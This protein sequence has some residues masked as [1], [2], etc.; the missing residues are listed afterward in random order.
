[1]DG[2]SLPSP[3]GLLRSFS[4]GGGRGWDKR[5]MSADS[6]DSAEDEVGLFLV[7]TSASLDL[8]LQETSKESKI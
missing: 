7:M 4:S 6:K 1:M 2:F 8:N 5:R 3:L